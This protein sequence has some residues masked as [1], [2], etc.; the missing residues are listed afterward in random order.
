VNIVTDTTTGTST[1]SR[2]MTAE[3]EPSGTGVTGQGGHFMSVILDAYCKF[4]GRWIDRFVDV[5]NVVRSALVSNLGQ[6]I[7]ARCAPTRKVHAEADIST[8]MF[9]PFCIGKPMLWHNDEA[10]KH[11]K[12]TTAWS[13][14]I[15]GE[16]ARDPDSKFVQFN[17]RQAHRTPL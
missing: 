16:F 4:Q 1:G 7:P 17:R 9:N 11:Y 5:F 10:V 12:P 15:I 8:F 6:G 3:T 13:K 14:A 2:D